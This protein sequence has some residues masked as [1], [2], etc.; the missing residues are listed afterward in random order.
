MARRPPSFAKE[1]AQHF[2]LPR[3]NFAV[4]RS[5]WDEVWRELAAQAIIDFKPRLASDKRT[6]WLPMYERVELGIVGLRYVG[7]IRDDEIGLLSG[8]GG[9]KVAEA[10]LD[11]E[12][13]G[14]LSGDGKCLFA[15]VGE[16]NARVWKPFLIGETDA[17]APAADVPDAPLFGE[18]LNEKLCLLARNKDRLCDAQREAVEIELM[19]DVLERSSTADEVNTALERL[20]GVRLSGSVEVEWKG[21]ALNIED[22]SKEALER[23]RRSRYVSKSCPL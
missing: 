5:T 12:W 4:K 11:V 13:G 3:A 19:R 7:R 10:E 2:P 15:N 1:G 18:A 20:E 23:W 14:V 17:A 22:V 8:K 21:S 6:L 16:D 9:E